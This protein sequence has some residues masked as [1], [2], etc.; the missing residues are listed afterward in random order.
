MRQ[1]PEGNCSL[2]Q[3]NFVEVYQM[4]IIFFNW[5]PFIARDRLS[6][7][8]SLHK[9]SD[10]SWI[11]LGHLTLE[12]IFYLIK[13]KCIFGITLNANEILIYGQWRINLDYRKSVRKCYT[14]SEM[15]GILNQNE[16]KT[17]KI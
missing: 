12:T 13:G 4:N 17:K 5:I 7:Q 16:N 15:W 10:I 14:P 2:L 9:Y 1:A 8:V 6:Y 11:Y 3:S